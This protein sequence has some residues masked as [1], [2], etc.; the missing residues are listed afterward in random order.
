MRIALLDPP[1]YSPAYDHHLAS[2]LAARGHGVELL[3]S[4]FAYGS[5]PEPGQYERQEL[6]WPLSGKLLRRSPRS[7]LRYV[8]KGVEYLPSVLRLVRGVAA[9]RPDVVHVQWLAFSR[10]DLRWV[11]RLRRDRPVVL[12]AHNVLPHVGEADPER[13]RRLYE[14]F[15]RVVVHTRSGAQ[16]LERFGVPAERIVRIPHGTFDAPPAERI[17]PPRG[18]TLLFYGL[19]RRYKG[20]D[21][22]VRALPEIPDARLVVAGDPLDRVEPLQKLARELGVA[23]RIDWR[24]G[25][26]PAEEVD[27]L[28]REATIA[29]FPYL[30]GES[31]SGTL[32]TALGHG[33]PA[34]VTEVLGETVEEYGAGLVV[35]PNDPKALAEACTRLLMDK[36]ALTET[37]HGTE[38]ARTALSWRAIA[39]AHERLYS[40]LTA[41]VTAAD[42]GD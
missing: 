31:A 21:V 39:E 42:D 24:L 25:Y 8:L 35:P 9:F 10:Y 4:P 30:S 7:R 29:V 15:D 41:R 40:D 38:W 22:L 27:A 19:I 12:T 11:Q 16:Q 34:V 20:L 26:L 32:A 6:F 13:R 5:A 33:R 18:R 36:A 2:A 1:S 3:T 23:D 14:A 37:F 28:M 17:E